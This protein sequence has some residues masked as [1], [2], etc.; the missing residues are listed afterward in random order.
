MSL[1][2][3]GRG[4][5]GIKSQSQ[6][7]KGAFKTRDFT[8]LKYGV[9]L[10]KDCLLNSPKFWQISVLSTQYEILDFFLEISIKH[11]R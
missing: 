4:K 7:F 1:T 5:Y 11:S 2:Q 10:R 6:D 3:L 8:V 9:K